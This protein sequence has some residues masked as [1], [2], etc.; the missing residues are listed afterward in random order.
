M[1]YEFQTTRRVEFADTDCAGIV[2]F[3]TFFRYLEEAEHAFLRSLGLS[4]R[5]PTA[6]GERTVIGFPRLSARC[7]YTRPARF[8]D[9]LDVHIWVS[10]KKSRTLEFSAVVTRAGEE[11]ARG[12]VAVIACRVREGHSIEPIELP[13]AFDR[14]LEEAPYPALEFFPERGGGPS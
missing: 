14:A 6:E 2:H 13:L 7:Q 9:E 8:E 10:R 3:A 12:Q 1:A 5:A 4:V 11:V